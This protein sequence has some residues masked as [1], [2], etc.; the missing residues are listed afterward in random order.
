VIKIGGGEDHERYLWIAQ[1]FWHSREKMLA[2]GQTGAASQPLG[3]LR[4]ESAIS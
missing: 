4:S 2:T 1:A 3:R